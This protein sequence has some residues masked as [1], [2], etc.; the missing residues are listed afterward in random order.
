MRFQLIIHY[1]GQ[2][3]C[4]FNLFNYTMKDKALVSSSFNCGNNENSAIEWGNILI[5]GETLG[6]QYMDI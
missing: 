6:Q 5:N 1:S 4:T 3:L 2:F